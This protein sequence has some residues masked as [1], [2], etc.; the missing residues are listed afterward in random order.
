MAY[1]EP[2]GEE[3]FSG[4]AYSASFQSTVDPVV[5]IEVRMGEGDSG[6]FFGPDSDALMQEVVDLLSAG[7][8]LEFVSAGRQWPQRRSLTPTPPPE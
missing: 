2:I 3:T 7:T 8:L 5:R 4:G 6:P 1:S